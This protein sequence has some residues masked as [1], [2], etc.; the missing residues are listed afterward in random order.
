MDKEKTLLRLSTQVDTLKAHINRL[1]KEGYE[2]HSMDMDVLRKNILQLYE[3]LVELSDISKSR[4]EHEIIKETDHNTTNNLPAENEP[5]DIGSVDLINDKQEGIVASDTVEN[6]GEELSHSAVEESDQIIEEKVEEPSVDKS[7]ADD[8]PIQDELKNE[9]P[10][11][12]TAYDLFS[13]TSDNAIAKQFTSDEDQSVG[14]KMQKTQVENIRE[15]I[16]INEKFLFINDIPSSH[17]NK[18]TM[19]KL[20]GTPF[21]SSAL[22]VAFI[23]PPVANMGSV[24]IRF[25]SA[26]E[27]V[28]I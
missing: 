8:T 11:A 22:M 13:T 4:D 18:Q 21:C 1:K 14:E 12:Q 3:M 2:I 24:M 5:N 20:L 15:A 23:D 16:G 19:C 9:E 27:G 7:S 10:A 17:A 6:E 26:T 28:D 25:L